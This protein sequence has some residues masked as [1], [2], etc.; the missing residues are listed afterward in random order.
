MKKLAAI[1]AI[2]FF[3]FG[4]LMGNWLVSSYNLLVQ[5]SSQV[6]TTYAAMETQYQR[7][8]DLVPNLAEATKGYL[9]QEQEVF[10]AIAQARTQYSGAKAGSPDAVEAMGN[11]SSAL[12]RLMVIVENYPE[13]KSDKTVQSLMDELSGTENRINVARD[14]YNETVRLYNVLLKSFPRNVLASM[15]GFEERAMFSSESGA[16][17]GVKIDMTTDLN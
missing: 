13:L 6:D 17:K 5:S 16:E 3:T 8:F 2:G 4:L 10:G 1:V 9:K 7:R 11:Y 15:Y 14:R 12:A